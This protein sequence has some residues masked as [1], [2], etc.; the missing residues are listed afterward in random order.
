MERKLFASFVDKTFQQQRS[1]GRLREGRLRGISPSQQVWQEL[2]R[3]SL[4]SIPRHFI[5]R[6][7]AHHNIGGGEKKA[8][9]SSFLQISLMLMLGRKGKVRSP[10]GLHVGAR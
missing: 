9:N 7:G 2:C 5:R 1:P 10:V 8:S 4:Q 3:S 6:G